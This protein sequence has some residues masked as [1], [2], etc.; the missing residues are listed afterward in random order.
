MG[1]RT[2]WLASRRRLN[3]EFVDD[4]GCWR[5]ITENNPSEVFPS[6]Q[7]HVDGVQLDR[8]TLLE[9]DLFHGSMGSSYGRSTLYPISR[10]ILTTSWRLLLQYCWLVGNR[11]CALWHWRWFKTTAVPNVLNNSSADRYFVNICTYAHFWPIV[12]WIILILI[13]L[14]CFFFFSSRSRENNCF[15]TLWLY[16]SLLY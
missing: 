2:R 7:V 14:F 13:E 11:A 16:W 8:Y 6:V 12:F 15:I 3:F 9:F 1:W 10:Q 4:G 5:G